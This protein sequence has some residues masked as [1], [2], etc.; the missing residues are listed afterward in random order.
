M[1]QTV[2]ERVLA[3]LKEHPSTALEVAKNMPAK[4]RHTRMGDT[5]IWGDWSFIRAEK[6]ELIEMDASGRYHVKEAEGR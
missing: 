4:R 3:Y 5:Y 6:A 1:R 2:T